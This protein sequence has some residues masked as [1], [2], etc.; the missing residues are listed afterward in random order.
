LVLVDTCVWV[1]HDRV[2]VPLLQ[3]LLLQSRV[4]TSSDVVNELRVGCGSSALELSNR[5]SA[6]PWIA[7]PDDRALMDLIPI[8]GLRCC[9]IGVADA[10]IVLAAHLADA[11]V[12][13]F[14]RNLK[15]V[16]ER[17]GCRFAP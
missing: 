3:E 5:V 12:L 13:T 10:R 6:L 2:G 8:L 15:Q 7:A 1:D 9:R 11:K 4:L 17:L 16:S 14:D